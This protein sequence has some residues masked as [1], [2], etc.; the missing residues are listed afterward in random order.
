MATAAELNVE[1]REA[2]G[3]RKVKQ[4]RKTGKI[5]AV[6]YGH[7]KE[8]VSLSVP[9]D[10]FGKII[11]KGDRIVS[12]KGGVASEAFIREVQWDVFGAQILH[13]DFTHVTAGEMLDTTVTIDVRGVAPGTKMGGVVEQPLHQM[14]I[15]IPPRSMTDRIEVVINELGLDEKITVGQLNLPEGAEI[16]LDPDLVVVQCVERQ[17]LPEEE[18]ESAVTGPAEPEVIGENKEDGGG[19]S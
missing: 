12:L 17:E 19:D 9:S 8:S 16:D 1:V 15:R 6:I 7:G 5:P 4:L 11:K 18:E 3:K 13:V 2:T 10:E 14:P